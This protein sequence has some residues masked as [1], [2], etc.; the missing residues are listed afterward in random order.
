MEE[1]IDITRFLDES[2]MI[3]Q[4]PGKQKPRR[5]VLEY[6]AAK[7]DPDVEYTEKQVNAICDEWHTFGD[8][9]LLRR[10]LVDSGLL[11]RER[12]GS[13]YWRTKESLSEEQDN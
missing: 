5:A 2:G 6:L 11:G 1:I 13:K 7:F 9:F 3:V 12:N 10:E 4:M 8:Y